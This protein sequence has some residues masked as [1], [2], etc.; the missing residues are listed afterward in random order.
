MIVG[1]AIVCPADSEYIVKSMKKQLMNEQL[2]QAE[3]RLSGRDGRGIAHEINNPLGIMMQEPAVQDVLEDDELDAERKIM[4]YRSLTKIRT[5]GP[6]KRLPTKLLS[7]RE[8]RTLSA[9]HWT[10][11]TDE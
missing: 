6:L 1:V 4:S 7:S 2:V 3:K 9:K 11:R 5:Q 8:R 10:Q